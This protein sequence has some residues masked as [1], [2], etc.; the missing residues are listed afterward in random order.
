MSYKQENC[1]KY[2]ENVGV[3]FIHSTTTLVLDC[4][5]EPDG[6]SIVIEPTAGIEGSN[7]NFGLR[8]NVHTAQVIHGLFSKTKY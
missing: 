5:Q 2:L 7:D 8:D 3:D 6:K 1:L 4:L